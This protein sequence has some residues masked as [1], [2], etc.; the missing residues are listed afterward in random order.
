[1]DPNRVQ[2][3]QQSFGRCLL[4]QSLEKSFL[5]A[6][7]EEFLASDPRIKP[8]FLKTDMEKQRNLL[9]QGLSMLIMYGTGSA[10][11]KSAVEQLA[12]KHDRKHLAIDPGMYRLWMKSLLAC[13]KRYDQKYDDSLN[14]IWTEV[15][16]LG[17][18]VMKEAY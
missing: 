15:L 11:A 9:R 8:M 17:I 10:L 18:D 5:D 13:I 4:N 7:Y 1:M 12:S 2:L 16:N 6:F 3:I 14:D